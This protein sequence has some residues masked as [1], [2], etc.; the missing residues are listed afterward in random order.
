MPKTRER[1]IKAHEFDPSPSPCVAP[2]NDN[3]MDN[4]YHFD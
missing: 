3:D 2:I 4:K 1:N